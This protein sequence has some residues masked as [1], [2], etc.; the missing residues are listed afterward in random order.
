MFAHKFEMFDRLYLDKDIHIPVEFILQD[1]V[2]YLNCFYISDGNVKT[3]AE[4]NSKE[5]FEAEKNELK[6]ILNCALIHVEFD[7]KK[8]FQN[9]SVKFT[10]N[11]EIDASD[12]RLSQYANSLQAVIMFAKVLDEMLKQ[13]KNYNTTTENL[14][15]QVAIETRKRL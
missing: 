10:G 3:P 2:A 14:M 6:N 11:S 7:E 13:D 5:L 1:I 4:I 8:V 12:Y 9:C 15:Y